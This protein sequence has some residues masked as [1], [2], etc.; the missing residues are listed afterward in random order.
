[1]VDLLI[2]DISTPIYHAMDQ[3]VVWVN[4]EYEEEWRVVSKWK[5]KWDRNLK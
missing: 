2:Y 4:E 3:I 5:S 1:M